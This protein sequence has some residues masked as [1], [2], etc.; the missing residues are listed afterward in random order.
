M[1]KHIKKIKVWNVGMVNQT[2]RE[3]QFIKQVERLTKIINLAK[4]IGPAGFMDACIRM[5]DNDEV[6]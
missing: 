4:R 5:V 2:D 3:I 6:S 1:K